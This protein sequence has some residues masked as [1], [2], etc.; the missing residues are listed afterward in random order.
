MYVSEC[1]SGCVSELVPGFA[2]GFAPGLVC[3]MF[4]PA[5][6]MYLFY[7][8]TCAGVENVLLPHFNWPFWGKV[9]DL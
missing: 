7:A 8:D 6:A 4:C 3:D 1:A 9:A 5:A 2:L